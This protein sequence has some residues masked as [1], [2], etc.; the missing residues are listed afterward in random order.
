MSGANRKL[1]SLREEQHSF[2]EPELLDLA[3]AV[4]G[5]SHFL[6]D[7]SFSNAYFIGRFVRASFF[8]NKGT[9]ARDRDYRFA[10]VLVY[11]KEAEQVRHVDVE[12]VINFEQHKMKTSGF[13]VSQHFVYLWNISQSPCAVLVVSSAVHIIDKHISQIPQNPGPNFQ[14]H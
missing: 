3:C 1:Q 12:H 10:E 13:Q 2:D 5:N 6:F 8:P 14:L 4:V 9:I 11:D 7:T